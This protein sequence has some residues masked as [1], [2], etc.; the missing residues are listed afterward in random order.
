MKVMKSSNVKCRSTRMNYR[1]IT[2]L[3]GYKYLLPNSKF[4]DTAKPNRFDIKPGHR[5]DGVE[6]GNKYEDRW[7]QRINDTNA[8]NGE[9]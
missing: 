5:W 6:R 2:T 1:L 8:K 4:G 7:F 9:A 3:S